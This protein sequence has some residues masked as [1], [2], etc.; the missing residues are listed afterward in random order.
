MRGL[1]AHQTQVVLFEQPCLR[2]DFAERAGYAPPAS[3]LPPTKT[4]A[5]S[6]N[7]AALHSE[8]AADVI[9]FKLT[10][11]GVPRVL[12]MIDQRRC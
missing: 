9:N 8:R 3:A 7:L 2:K 6:K 4:P 5:R 10:K 12:A 11:S 1:G